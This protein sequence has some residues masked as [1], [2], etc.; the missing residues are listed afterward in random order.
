MIKKVWARF[1]YTEWLWI[2]FLYHFFV[3]KKVFKKAHWHVVFSSDIPAGAGCS[4]CKIWIMAEIAK[5]KSQEK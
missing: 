5:D 2:D 1:I 4:K 3:C